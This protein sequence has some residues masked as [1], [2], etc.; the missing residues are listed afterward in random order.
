MIPIIKHSLQ[1]L[2][3]R[4]RTKWISLILLLKALNL[5]VVAVITSVYSSLVSHNMGIKGLQTTIENNLDLIC[6]SAQKIQG[7]LVID[8]VNV[9]HEL[10][11]HHN[12][13][14]ANG[15]C[16]L[17]VHEVTVGFFDNLQKAGVRPI[18]I[19]DGAGIESHLQDKVYRRN[20]SISKIPACIE[21]VH[22]PGYSHE[23]ES[24][25]FHPELSRMTFVTAV[26]E[27]SSV[28]LYFADGKA[29]TT[30]VKLTNYYGCPVLGNDTKYCIFNV[31]NGVILYRHLK[32]DLSTNTCTAHVTERGRPFQE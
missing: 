2:K 4:S 24:R 12:L 23:S 30:V 1:T 32:L 20:L 13:D 15:G 29:N 7:R 19:M 27:L 14:W 6:G 21:R 28:P 9:L 18:V 25:H 22:T 11:L 26:K 3:I 10:Y 8:G 16:Y 17:K 5:Q 31:Y